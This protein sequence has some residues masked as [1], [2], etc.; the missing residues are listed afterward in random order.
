MFKT[1]TKTVTTS[2]ERSYLLVTDLSTAPCDWMSAARQVTKAMDEL[3]S[4]VCA[5]CEDA[6]PAS[7]L[8]SEFT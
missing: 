3:K 2:H 1:E 5:T 4:Q 6:G 7:A 8:G